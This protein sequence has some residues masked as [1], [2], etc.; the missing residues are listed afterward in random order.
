LKSNK[1]SILLLFG[2]LV[3]AAIIVVA[4]PSRSQDFSTR[5]GQRPGDEVQM[6]IA[7]FALPDPT[8]AKERAMRKARG[9]RYD[10]PGQ[11]PIAELELGTEPLPL[12]NHWWWSIPALPVNKSDAI[13]VG[14]ILSAQAYLSSDKTGVYSEFRIDISEVLKNA[15]GATLLSRSEVIATRQGGIVRFP[16]GR[17]QR[18]TTAQQGMPIVGRRYVF[19]LRCNVSGQE[20]S[21]LTAYELRNDRVLPLDGYGDKGERALPS[22]TKFEGMEETVFLKTV[23]DAISNPPK[24]SPEKGQQE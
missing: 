18:Y 16:S 17:Q 11:K 21:L 14:E 22:F 2:L 15:G 24:D 7:D 10:N 3:L 23:A 9:S 8:D 13:V 20:F 4:L 19:F 12:N 1:D 5:L 6:P